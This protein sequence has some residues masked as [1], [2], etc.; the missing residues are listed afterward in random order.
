MRSETLHA[1]A[2]ADRV[3]V[4]MRRELLGEILGA[5]KCGPALARA[6]DVGSM[7]DS[8][9]LDDAFQLVWHVHNSIRAPSRDPQSGQLALQGMADSEGLRAQWAEH[10]FNDCYRYFV[11]QSRERTLGRRR[12]VELPGLLGQRA[13]Y[14]ARNAS[15]STE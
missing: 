9:D 11:G 6:I 4:A 1:C 2:M 3:C 8:H 10:E 5:W 15:A 13:R 14:L 12:N 7:I